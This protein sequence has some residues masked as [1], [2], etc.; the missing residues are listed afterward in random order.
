MARYLGG[1]LT[2]DESQVLP[3][4]NY[5]DTSG[6]AVFTS[7]EQYLLNKSNL[8]PTPGIFSPTDRAIFV[9]GDDGS[10]INTM[11]FVNISSLGNA[12]DFGDYGGTI[13]HAA[14]MA[15]STIGVIGGGKY[16]GS[17]TNIMEFVTIA[18]EGNS[19]DFG[20]LT[21]VR[22][23]I[24][25]SNGVASSVARG[26]FT[27]GLNSSSNGT[28]DKMLVLITSSGYNAVTFNYLQLSRY[29]H[30]DVA[31]ETRCI[32]MGGLNYNSTAYLNS[33][34]YSTFASNSGGTDFGDLTE[35]VGGSPAGASSGTRGVRA[36][37]QTGSGKT[38]VIDYITIASTG[39]ATDFG[40]LASATVYI[41]GTSNA[42]RGIFGGGTDATN[43]LSNTIEYITIASTGNTSDFGDLSASKKFVTAF[44]GSHGG[45]Q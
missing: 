42:T 23:R 45:L 37:G 18:T 14:S 34:E 30:V 4:D 27:G 31:S 33:I 21:A 32:T 3:S 36:G 25:G 39:N 6:N 13:A 17:Q 2:A 10:A 24:G 29:D 20:D 41:A 16:N 15:S 7:D 38:N 44:S 12:S 22:S 8:W 43:S 35:S 9:G 19:S 40:D 28:Q 1:L 26:F 11:E 5:Q